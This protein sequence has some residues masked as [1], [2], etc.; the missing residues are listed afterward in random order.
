[1]LELT[2]VTYQL[3]QNEIDVSYQRAVVVIAVTKTRVD[4]S[5]RGENVSTA[6]CKNS[7]MLV[8]VRCLPPATRAQLWSGDDEDV[9]HDQ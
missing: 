2:L 9:S 5:T 8:R 7:S 6:Q 3:R 1:M 4:L